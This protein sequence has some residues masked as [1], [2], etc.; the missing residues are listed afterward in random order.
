MSI[1][2]PKI[3]KI[4]SVNNDQQTINITIKTKNFAKGIHLT[5]NSLGNF[6]DNYFDLPI[7]G[8]KTVTMALPKD[9]DVPELIS[10][11]KVFSLWDTLK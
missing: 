11:I 5:T 8:E 1:T 9:I 7:N 10:S 3:K 6:S 2:D 4:I